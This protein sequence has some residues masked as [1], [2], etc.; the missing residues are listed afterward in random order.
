MQAR[1]FRGK[2]RNGIHVK[3]GILPLEDS[4]LM[5]VFFDLLGLFEAEES[6]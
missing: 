2:T 6:G 4:G 1:C 5:S 3:A